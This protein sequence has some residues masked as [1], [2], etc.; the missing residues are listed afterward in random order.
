M[1]QCLLTPAVLPSR[2]AGSA[3]WELRQGHSS[4]L[5]EPMHVLAPVDNLSLSLKLSD[6]AAC[7]RSYV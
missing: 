5:S 3:F 1:M 2:R 4:L 6:S 7:R